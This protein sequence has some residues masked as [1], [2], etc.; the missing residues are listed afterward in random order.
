MGDNKIPA[1]TAAQFV[2]DELLMDGTPALNLASFVTTYMEE[3]AEKLV[4]KNLSKVSPA[5][6]ISCIVTCN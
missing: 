5:P 2:Y 3:E 4:V 6:S 1:H